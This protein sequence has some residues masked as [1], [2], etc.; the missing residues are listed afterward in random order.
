MSN[1][2]PEVLVARAKQIADEVLFPNALAAD[3]ATGVPEKQLQFLADNGFYAMST[4]CEPPTIFEVLEALASGCVTTSFVYAQ[5]LGACASAFTSEGPVRAELADD[6]ASG[7][8][9]GGVAFAHILR[10]GTPLTTAQRVAGGWEITGTAPWVTGWGHIDVVHAAARHGDDIVWSLIDAVDSET[11]TTMPVDFAVVDATQTRELTYQS[12]FVPDSRVTRVENYDEWRAKYKLGLRA[13]GSLALGVASRC[14]RLLDEP[15]LTTQLDGLRK[16][17]DSIAAQDHAA[18]T[19]ARS[20]ASLFAVQVATALVAKTGGNA[21][22]MSNH[23]QRLMREAMFTVVQGQNPEI[24]AA[25]LR[26]LTTRHV[27]A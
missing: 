10:P 11:L 27:S 4:Y 5:H 17:L 15:E 9:R 25:M 21:V 13:N 8:K 12:H 7:F 16:K 26:Q 24:R 14:C 6:L 22:M 1:P 18:M 2:S 3:Q 19:S 20:E 23:A